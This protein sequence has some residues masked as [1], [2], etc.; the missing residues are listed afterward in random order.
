[1]TVTGTTMKNI[2]L[3]SD[4]TGNAG[5]KKNGTNVW[6]LYLAVDTVN[7]TSG[8]PRQVAFHD[9]GV[10]SQ[11]YKFL[12]AIG[13]ITGF[14]LGENIR[15][16]YASLVRTYN[17]GDQIFLFGFSR[18]A[19]TARA[20]AGLI[21]HCGILKRTSCPT[22]GQLTDTVKDLYSI[23][24]D[25][26]WDDPAKAKA[27]VAKLAPYERHKSVGE[28]PANGFK[29]TFVGVWDTVDA[30]GV[31]F[32]GLR[33]ILQK[34]IRVIR[35]HQHDL[36]PSIAHAYHALS[37]DDMRETFHPL[38]FDETKAH[39]H[40][41]V[42]QVWFTGVHSN[43]GGGYPKDQLALVTLDWMMD[44]A[45]NLDKLAGSTYHPLRFT[46][47]LR[48][49]HRDGANVD[50]KLYDSRSG[51][52]SYYRY[53]PR[54]IKRLCQDSTKHVPV[55]HKS[56]FRRIRNRTGGYAPFNIP[57]KCETVGTAQP[58]NATAFVDHGAKTADA[59]RLAT[60][61]S[62]WQV[63]LYY[64]IL[65][66]TAVFAVYVVS[67]NVM[68]QANA[69][70]EKGVLIPFLKLIL[71]EFLSNWIVGALGRFDYLLVFS[72][73]Y[74]LLV[75]VGRS[76]LRNLIYDMS[77]MG[78]RHWYLCEWLAVPANA[79]HPN[80]AANTKEKQDLEARFKKIGDSCLKAFLELGN[81]GKRY[82]FRIV[83]ALLCLSVGIYMMVNQVQSS[84]H[85][86]LACTPQHNGIG[87][88]GAAHFKSFQTKD[89]CFRT[90]VALE[91]GKRFK[92]N[93]AVTTKWRDKTI[94]AT[95][96]GFDNKEKQ[97]GWLM[98]LWSHVLRSRQS[99][100]IEKHDYFILM[101]QIVDAENG[102]L[103]PRGEP[104]RIGSEGNALTAAETGT[105]VLF[106]NDVDCR[107]CPFWRF[108]LYGNN[109]GTANFA[110]RKLP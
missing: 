3:C 39:A 96:D 44:K 51:L 109:K 88:D 90:D 99:M 102:S 31:P 91:K 87:R 56:V 97:D 10:G 86:D 98:K 22:P 76:L 104:F 94:P 84:W 35:D 57:T 108:A 60:R 95:P 75:F 42:E 68:T 62:G 78:W 85:F 13:G 92:V 82:W 66:V 18:G 80:H 79:T 38:L 63:K 70:I 105:L 12:K 9:D 65:F 50:G 49:Q 27:A 54:N 46:K 83:V 89:P 36:T 41:K 11:D 26:K 45:E 24:R 17:P 8:E 73:V 64:V 74:I 6:R 71:P 21:H 93:V 55:V 33:T 107:W 100:T 47:P 2:V 16:L 58:A 72:A 61:L 53:K 32:D 69:T 1:M 5:G 40:A 59:T 52:G 19:Y 29:I 101:G 25:T 110:I 15:H 20:L 14:G 4:G 77:G 48:D 28:D 7:N 81:I 106:V 23:Y 30:I 67:A 34:W 103:E 37:V 43:V